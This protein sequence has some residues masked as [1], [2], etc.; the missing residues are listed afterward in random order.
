MFKTD[1]G[2]LGRIPGSAVAWGSHQLPQPREG[3]PAQMST[4]VEAERMGLVRITYELMSS[5]HHKSRHWYWCAIYAEKA[6]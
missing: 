1:N 3:Q 4:T 6:E 2:I 5:R